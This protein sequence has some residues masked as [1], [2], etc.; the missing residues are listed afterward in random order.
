MILFLGFSLNDM[1]KASSVGSPF[2]TVCKGRNGIVKLNGESS[3]L[4][5]VGFGGAFSWSLLIFVTFHVP[6]LFCVCRSFSRLSLRRAFFV[7]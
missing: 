7:H 5:F 4:L 3:S 6:V 2:L 1:L